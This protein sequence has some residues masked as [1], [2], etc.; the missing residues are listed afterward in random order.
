M[1]NDTRKTVSFPSSTVDAVRRFDTTAQYWEE[2]YRRGGNSGA[3]SFDHLGAYKA[4]FLNDFIRKNA[5]QTVLEFGCGD[6]VQLSQFGCPRYIGVDVSPS[7]IELCTSKF[8]ADPTK[9]FLLLSELSPEKSADLTLSLDVIYHLIEDDVYDRYMKALFSHAES[10]VVVYSSNETGKLAPHVRHR[11]FTDWVSTNAPDWALIDKFD[12]PF[13]YDAQNPAGTTFSNFYVFGKAAE[14]SVAAAGESQDGE[15]TM[16]FNQA[17]YWIERHRNYTDDPRSVGNLA[18]DLESNRSGEAELQTLIT[19][20]A[21]FLGKAAVLDLGCG[22]GRVA[23]A[24]LSNGYAYTGYDVSPEAVE[25]ARRNN[26]GATFEVVD[27]NSWTAA[28][29]FEV[30]CALYVFVHFVDDG[31]WRKIVTNSVKSVGE[32]GRLLIADHFP[33]EREA[34]VAHVT[35]RPLDAYNELFE[36]LGMVWDRSLEEDLKQTFSSNPHAKQVRC[37]RHKS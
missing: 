6:G 10:F 18:A 3:G 35:A 5:V 20:C 29:T 33:A 32:N 13:P 11:R 12:Q 34:Q 16:G 1:N 21:A 2:R 14:A 26:P 23:N 17:K 15:E 37:L 25:A 28:G 9:S 4:S 36:T 27:L 19:H 7:A 8:A 31:D 30:V 22:Y 24:F